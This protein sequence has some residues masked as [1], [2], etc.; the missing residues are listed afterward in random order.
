MCDL[1]CERYNVFT[2]S[3]PLV[4][5]MDAKIWLP[6]PSPP[7]SFYLRKERIFGANLP[8]TLLRFCQEGEL[9]TYGKISECTSMYSWV[10][11]LLPKSKG[12]PALYVKLSQ[13]E[14]KER[15]AIVRQP[16]EAVR[17]SISSRLF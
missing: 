5:K 12:A 2:F 15:F 13:R 10:K 14:G 3:L 9:G 7:S 11:K 4:T 8:E 1:L 17:V 16:K 6:S